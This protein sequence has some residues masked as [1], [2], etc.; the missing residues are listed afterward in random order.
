LLCS[1]QC[2]LLYGAQS[3][4]TM[5]PSTAEWAASSVS[6]QHPTPSAL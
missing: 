6:V 4:I 5:R 1:N 3:C 2:Q